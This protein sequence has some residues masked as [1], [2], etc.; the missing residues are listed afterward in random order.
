MIL[1]GSHQGPYTFFSMFDVTQFKYGLKNTSIPPPHWHHSFVFKLIRKEHLATTIPFLFTFWVSLIIHKSVQQPYA[2][3]EIQHR[4]ALKLNS[5]CIERKRKRN[6]NK[7]KI[8]IE[9]GLYLFVSNFELKKM[10]ANALH[11]ILLL[12]VD[13]NIILFFLNCWCWIIEWLF[14]LSAISRPLSN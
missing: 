14:C 4:R 10:K 1:A 5:A 3:P 8:A 12:D 13:L 6:E 9:E 7:K 2:S 11:N